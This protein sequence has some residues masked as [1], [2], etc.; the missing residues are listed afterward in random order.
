MY[1]LGGHEDWEVV[2]DGDGARWCSKAGN[3]GGVGGGLVALEVMVALDTVVAAMV[4]VTVVGC[5]RQ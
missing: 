1:W 5:G 3:S 4:E 2:G